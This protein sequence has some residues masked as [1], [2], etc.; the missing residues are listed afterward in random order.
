[1]QFLLE[2]PVA[3]PEGSQF[4]L[5]GPHRE[6]GRLA[7]FLLSVTAGKDTETKLLVLGQ[8][9]LKEGQLLSKRKNFIPTLQGRG[10]ALARASAGDNA[11]SIDELAVLR[12]E[13][14]G[15]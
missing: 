8:F 2:Q 11:R 15:R 13:S 14:G 7:G 10:N 6:A 5:L 3:R 4:V 9:G 12:G 1:L